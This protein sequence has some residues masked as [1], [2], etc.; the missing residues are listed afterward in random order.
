MVV[1]TNLPKHP[2]R[3]KSVKTPLQK[4]QIL[5]KTKLATDVNTYASRRIDIDHNMPS[6]ATW[7]SALALYRLSIM[8][9]QSNEVGG[10]DPG[11]H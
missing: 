11:I 3:N 8:L 1:K 10:D 9:K 2:R 5:Q 6:V 4:P 7:S